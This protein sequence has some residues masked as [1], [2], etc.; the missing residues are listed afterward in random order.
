MSECRAGYADVTL[1][2]VGLGAGGGTGEGVAIGTG[3]SYRLT[4]LLEQAAKRLGVPVTTRG[5]GPHFGM[6]RALS[7]GGRTAL[8]A[9]LSWDGSDQYAHTV[10][11]SV[12]KLDPEKMGKLGRLVTLTVMVLTRETSY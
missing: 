2:V 12:D 9:Y 1:G 3:T 4:K 8:S 6:D 5:R 7:F 11:D 10:L